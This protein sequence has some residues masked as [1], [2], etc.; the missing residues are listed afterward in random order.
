MN[1]D[2]GAAP[3]FTGRIY[4][5]GGSRF[6]VPG[7]ETPGYFRQSLR[8]AVSRISPPRRGDR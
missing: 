7:V 1:R 4:E 2:T 6:S 3:P 8:D 5:L